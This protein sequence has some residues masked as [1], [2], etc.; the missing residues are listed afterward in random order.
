MGFIYKI[1]NKKTNEIYIGQTKRSVALR[2]WE[3]LTEKSNPK[4]KLYQALHE[5]SIDDFDISIIEECDNSLLDKREQFWIEKFDSFQSGY[6]GT[7]GGS[8][9]QFDYEAIANDFIKTK[10]TYLTKKNFNCSIQTVKRALQTYN[11]PYNNQ[12]KL[13]IEIDQ[14]DAK[15]LQIIATYSSISAAIE[16]NPK[17]NIST[18]SQAVSGSR[19]SAYGFYWQRHRENKH[20]EPNKAQKERIEIEQY[21]KDGVLLN[22]FSSIADANRF[23]GKQ[24]YDGSIS[25]VINGKQKTAFGFVWKR[26]E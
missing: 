16:K 12:E 2:W 9:I 11:I 3:H 19:K 20:F 25:K 7:R 10:N 21:N 22:T 8:G 13:P 24:Q 26:K 1:E 14:I 17:W 23:L 5:N 15:T 6:N 4:N 18:I